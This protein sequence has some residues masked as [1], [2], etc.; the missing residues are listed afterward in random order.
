MNVKWMQNVYK[1][2]TRSNSDFWKYS[3]TPTH[4]VLHCKEPM[5]HEEVAS[6]QFS[7]LTKCNNNVLD[8]PFLLADNTNVKTSNTSRLKKYGLLTD[9]YERQH[10]STVSH[11]KL[12]QMHMWK[13]TFMFNFSDSKCN[14]VTVHLKQ[15]EQKGNWK[16][17]LWFFVKNILKG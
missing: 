11:V 10:T 13:Q 12:Y 14:F 7:V 8:L 9:Q 1:F 6:L 17:S 2:F 15:T 4:N 3:K 16:N 5:W